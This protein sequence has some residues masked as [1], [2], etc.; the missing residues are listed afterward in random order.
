MPGMWSSMRARLDLCSLADSMADGPPLA[1]MTSN[2]GQTGYGLHH[3]CAFLTR[4]VVA[5]VVPFGE[6]NGMG[7]PIH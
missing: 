1:A 7:R 3:F 5:K 2:P 6:A 4:E